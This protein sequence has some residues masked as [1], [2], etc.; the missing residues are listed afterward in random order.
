MFHM[1]HF[2]KETG[3]RYGYQPRAL[4]VRCH[5]WGRPCITNIHGSNLDVKEIF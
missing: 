4:P 3:A 2:T 1:E 5:L